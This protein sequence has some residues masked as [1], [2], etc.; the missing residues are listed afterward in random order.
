MAIELLH[1]L[2]LPATACCALQKSRVW[3]ASTGRRAVLRGTSHGTWVPMSSLRHRDPS[4]EIV[5]QR[6]L[7]PSRAIG[8]APSGAAARIGPRNVTPALKF[9][10]LTLVI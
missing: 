8:Y 6:R 3:P 10:A 5:K 9:D 4:L 2:L 1:D 7:R